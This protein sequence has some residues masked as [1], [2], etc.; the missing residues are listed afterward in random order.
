[1]K[2]HGQ[3]LLVRALIALLVALAVALAPLPVWSPAWIP[4]VQVPVA[5]FLLVCYLGKLLY[6][7]LFDPGPKRP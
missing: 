4:W 6:D 2:R 1:M 7:T 3:R 5:V